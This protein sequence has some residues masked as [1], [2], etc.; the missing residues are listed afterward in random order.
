MIRG[1]DA[2]RDKLATL[3]P[4][5]RRSRAHGLW[6]ALGDLNK[7]RGSRPFEA[8]YTWGYYQERKVAS[9]D[10]AFVRMLNEC[11]WVPDSSGSL[12]RPGSIA[13]ED[14]DWKPNS[15]LESK[16]RFKAAFTGAVG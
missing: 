9:F 2:L 6:E 10:P 16:I 7:R 11:R 14:V 8:V 3:D 12:H 1:L 5:E 4:V 13:F 15:F